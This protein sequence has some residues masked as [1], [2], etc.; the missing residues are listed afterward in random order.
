MEPCGFTM[1]V[2][3]P[4]G[5]PF[6]SPLSPAGEVL[7]RS[8]ALFNRRLF[9]LSPAPSGAF[10]ALAAH[11]RFRDEAIPPPTSMLFFPFPAIHGAGPIWIIVAFSRQSVGGAEFLFCFEGGTLW[12]NWSFAYHH[13][14]V[15]KLWSQKNRGGLVRSP[16]P[17]SPFL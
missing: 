13:G 3:A 7:L 15:L 4:P 8:N 12:D 9:S 11:L 10:A 6:W 14:A 5:A 1:A 17:R 16:D 2:E